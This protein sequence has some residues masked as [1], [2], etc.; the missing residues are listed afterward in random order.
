MSI[1][2]STS[3]SHSP[4]AVSRDR[5]LRIER[6]ALGTLIGALRSRGYR[7]IGPTVRE[8]RLVHGDILSDADLPAGWRDVQE[9]GRYRLEHHD[10][11]P[12]VFG[13]NVGPVSWKQLFFP[14]RLP[15]VRFERDAEGAW[16]VAGG[17]ATAGP[18]PLA[19]FGVRACDLAAIAVHDRVLAEGAHPDPHYVERRRDNFVVAVDCAHA[20]G[21]CFCVAAA[22]GP[23]ATRGYDVA[24]TEVVDGDEHFFLAR[25]GSERGAEV[26]DAVPHRDAGDDDV[27]R[28]IATVARTAAAMQRSMDMEAARTVLLQSLDSRHWDDVASRCLA[29]GNCTLVCPTCFCTAVEDEADLAGAQAQRTRVW[30][31]CFASSHSYIHGGS[32]RGGTPSR[33]RQWIVHKLATWVDQFGTAGCVGCGR[34]ITW[35]PVGIDITAEVAALQRSTEDRP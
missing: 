6:P 20:G 16:A 29:C 1:S 3:P 34:C 31:S 22:T 33:Y 25:T 7:V 27:A 10:G 12:A 32:V 14:D 15:L 8:G 4:A 17:A 30:D 18:Q 26:L 11:D 19:L 2:T 24:L 21:T 28:A 9:A 5:Q 35:C 13:H 23:A